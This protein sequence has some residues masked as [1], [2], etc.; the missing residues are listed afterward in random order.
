MLN[1]GGLDGLNF[2]A[3]ILQIASYEELLKQ[4]NNDDIMQ[5]LD[6]QNQAYLEQILRNQAEIIKRL[7]RLE[8][9]RKGK[10]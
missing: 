5:E 1:F 7:E 2:Y 10:K 6:H 9:E 8:N 4:A 3:N